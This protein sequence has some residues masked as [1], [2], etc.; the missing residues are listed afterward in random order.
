MYK[1]KQWS[2]CMSYTSQGYVC[3]YAKGNE[4]IWDQMSCTQ[5]AV[6]SPCLSEAGSWTTVTSLHLRSVKTDYSHKP[7]HSAFLSSDLHL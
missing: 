4:W 5:K 7:L 2:A 6:I 1:N 3:F